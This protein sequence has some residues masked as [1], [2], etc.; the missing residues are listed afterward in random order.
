MKR[1]PKGQTD[2]D[3][4]ED[5]RENVSISDLSEYEKDRNLPFYKAQNK[6]WETGDFDCLWEVYPVIRNVCISLAKQ[7]AVGIRIPDLIFKAED[8]ALRVLAI[9]KS[10]K[11][12]YVK[13]LE[14]VCYWKVKEVL[15]N[16]NLQI[17]E[18]TADISDFYNLSYEYETEE[19]KAQRLKEEE[20]ERLKRFNSEKKE[21]PNGQLFLEF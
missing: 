18:R 5:Y 16:Q 15:F 10:N 20:V 3:F 14:N 13:K 7:Q 1:T 9:Y 4:F 21:D 19:E 8:A 12:F 11:T 2:F 6:Y 17:D